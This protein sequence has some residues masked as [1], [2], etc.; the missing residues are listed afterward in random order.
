M[1]Q[2]GQ[3]SGDCLCRFF[4]IVTGVFQACR[5]NISV[6]TGQLLDARAES[7]ISM[8][9]MMGARPSIV[10]VYGRVVIIVSMGCAK[11]LPYK[12]T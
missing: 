7:V 8:R 6:G 9:L 1:R 2:G 5:A 12:I 3:N 4:R 11:I 10:K